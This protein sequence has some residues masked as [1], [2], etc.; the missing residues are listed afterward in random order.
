[1][2]EQLAAIF[3]AD[4]MGKIR[5]TAADAEKMDR[6]VEPDLALA[7]ADGLRGTPT[8]VVVKNG[9]R[10]PVLPVPP[11]AQLEGTLTA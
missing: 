2:D 8:L 1:M 5:A 10:H 4:V 6:L 3:P 7:Y 11:L 9:I